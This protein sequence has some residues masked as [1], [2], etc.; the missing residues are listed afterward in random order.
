MQSAELIRQQQYCFGGDRKEVIAWLQD[1]A[2]NGATHL[3]I[4]FTGAKDR[5]QMD[6][7]K[8]IREELVH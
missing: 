2:N 4:R 8:R 5:E 3:C 1:F 7:L 6:E